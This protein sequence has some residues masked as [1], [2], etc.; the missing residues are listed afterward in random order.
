ML[1]MLERVPVSDRVAGVAELAGATPPPTNFAD[2]AERTAQAWTKV[3]A[4]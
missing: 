3:S 2:F 4:R 1:S